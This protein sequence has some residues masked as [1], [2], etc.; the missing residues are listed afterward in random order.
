MKDSIFAR[1]QRGEL[2]DTLS[3]E[4]I[5]QL[6]RCGA[7]NPNGT[8]GRDDPLFDALRN[9]VKCGL[10]PPARTEE[11]TRPGRVYASVGKQPIKTSSSPAMRYFV[12]HADLLPHRA[13]LDGI[14]PELVRWIGDGEES[15]H[16][17]SEPDEG[18][19]DTRVQRWALEWHGDWA[20]IERVLGGAVELKKECEIFD[21]KGAFNF[22]PQQLFEAMKSHNEKAVPPWK[23]PT[24][25]KALK[26]L[27]PSFTFAKG[28]RSE[29]QETVD[30]LL[31]C[32][33]EGAILAADDELDDKLPA[34]VVDLLSKRA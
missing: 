13:H 26:A 17:A 12:H 22:S 1:S 6:S 20:P 29:K 2:G 24:L 7:L 8:G 15:A 18:H 11:R 14:G 30:V 27:Y 16:S 19:R 10:L 23:E 21:G 4:E 3:L 34:N 31:Q 32:Y 25:S 28:H 33:T 9:L 5:A